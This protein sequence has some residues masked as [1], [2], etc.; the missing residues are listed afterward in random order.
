M[1]GR[2]EATLIVMA[3]GAQLAEH[4]SP[5]AATLHVITGSV[6]LSTHDHETGSSIAVG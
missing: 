2:P 1:S 4:D 5:P 3:E 6:R